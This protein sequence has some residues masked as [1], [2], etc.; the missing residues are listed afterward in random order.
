[1]YVLSKWSDQL[2]PGARVE[3]PAPAQHSIIYIDRGSATLN[4][5]A[6]SA[7]DSFYVENSLH[8]LAGPEGVTLWRWAI[9][10]VGGGESGHLRAPGVVSVH[11]MSRAIKMFEMYPTTRWLF[12][13]DEILNFEGTT[14]LHSHPGSGIRCLLT[15]ALRTE[16][17]KNENG[18]S[19]TRGDVWYEEGAYPLVTT[20]DAGLKSSFLRGLIL[21]PE[22]VGLK[23]TASWISGLAAT[24][25]GSIVHQDKIITLR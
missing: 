16:S 7:G 9:Q 25:D 10:S 2:S 18:Y 19:S 11:R 24:Y 6:L 3:Q 4:D 14:G 5:Q 22:Y 17:E 12:R 23:D 15:G 1:M 21:P 13:L 20:V 8:L